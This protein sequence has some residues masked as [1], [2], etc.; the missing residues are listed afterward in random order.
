VCRPGD[1]LD[2]DVT[3]RVAVGDLDADRVLLTQALDIGGGAGVDDGIG[4]KFAGEDDGVVHYV[5]EAPPLERVTDKRSR[6]GDRASDRLKSGRC[7][8]RDHWSPC[9]CLGALPEPVP[10]AV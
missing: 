6:R 7:P 10:P 9:G 2:R 3:F 5:G 4:D 1:I 8:C